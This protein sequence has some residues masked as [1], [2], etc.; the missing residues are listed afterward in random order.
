MTQAE[1]ALRRGRAVTD[2]RNAYKRG[3]R[4]ADNPEMT[5]AGTI[6]A[7]PEWLTTIRVRDLV[8][9]L[10]SVGPA[11]AKRLATRA[12]IFDEDTR[13]NELTDRERRMLV[14]VVQER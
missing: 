13:L 3:L 14:T 10:P 5:L 7:N 12:G 4:E 11:R 2:R 9:F 1:A 6:E 8:R